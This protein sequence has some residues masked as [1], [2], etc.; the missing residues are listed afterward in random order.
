MVALT[1]ESLSLLNL[2]APSFF[3]SLKSNLGFT[4]DL[5][6]LA[7]A[8]AVQLLDND[9]EFSHTVLVQIL[10]LPRPQKCVAH[11]AST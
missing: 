4:P 11:M 5:F 2:T 9:G 10:P 6:D 8:M 3:V 7:F 1:V